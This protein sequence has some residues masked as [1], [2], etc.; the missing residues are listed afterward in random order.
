[1]PR[2]SSAWAGVLADAKLIIEPSPTALALWAFNLHRF[3][4]LQ[5]S[6]QTELGRGTL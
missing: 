3:G 2:P 6:A 4:W 1:V 5:I